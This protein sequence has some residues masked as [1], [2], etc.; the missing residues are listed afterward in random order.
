MKHRIA[1]VAAL[2]VA[3]AS[4]SLSCKRAPTMDDP[5]KSPAREMVI[6]LGETVR[7]FMQANDLPAE[8]GRVDV[9][10]TNHYAVAVDVIA[11]TSPIVFGDHW[12]HLTVKDGKATFDLPAGRTLFIDQEAGRIKSFSLTPYASAQP[13][14]ETNRLVKTVVDGFLA[15]GW[16]PKVA[17]SVTFALTDQ[18]KDFAQRGEKIYAQ[19]NDATGNLLNVTVANLASAPSQ[20]SYLVV[21]SPERPTHNPPVYVVRLGLYWAHRNDL[22]YG[23]LVYPRRIFVNGDKNKVLRLRPWVED[24]DWTPQQH[25]MADQGGQGESKRW[26]LPQS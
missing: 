11:D 2:L 10:D 21:P 18:D 22:S 14:D 17:N 4:A 16:T 15:R 25:G 20:P 23:D 13:L 3:S 5:S 26:S 6:S 24:P 12:I 19:L 9:P 8:K 7:D 1:T